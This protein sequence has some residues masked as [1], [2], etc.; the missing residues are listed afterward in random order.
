MFSKK[1]INDCENRLCF[2]NWK[3]KG[4]EKILEPSLWKGPKVGG[5]GN[6]CCLRESRNLLRLLNTLL[7]PATG[8]GLLELPQNFS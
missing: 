2:H 6:T 7:L 4:G 5:G 1:I 3:L 8:W